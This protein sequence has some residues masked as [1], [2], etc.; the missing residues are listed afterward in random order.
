MKHK[1][2]K[3]SRR[4]FSRLLLKGMALGPTGLTMTKSTA[5]QTAAPR[6]FLHV[7][8]RGGWD[9]AFATDPVV[10][11]K[12]TAGGYDTTYANYSVTSIAGKA[13]L[14]VG[15]GLA[16]AADAF[17]NLPTAFVNGM[18]LDV[19]AHELAENYLYSGRASLTLSRTYPAIAALMGQATG[20]FPGHVVLGPSV[21]LGDSGE[22]APVL[23]AS[24]IDTLPVIL[25]GAGAS[26]TWNTASAAAVNAYV[27]QLDS[28]S[29]QTRDASFASSVTGWEEAAAHLD[30][31]Y[32]AA[33]GPML[34]LDNSTKSRYG[35]TTN[36]DL[37]AMLAGAYLT[38]KSGLCPYVTVSFG[39]FDTHDSQITRQLPTLQAFASAF[40]VLIN[41][42][43]STSDP[44]DSTLTLAD[45]TTIVIGSEFSRT[46]KF[47]ADSGTDHWP[48]AS[49][50][51]MGK[52]VRDNTVIGA[53]DDSAMAM[54]WTSSG[55]SSLESSNALLPE[56]IFAALLR[57]FGF[58]SAAATISGAPVDGLFT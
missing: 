25:T 15:A 43:R 8:L 16:A 56:H 29:R 35:S 47:N 40:N 9:T 57:N 11:S 32:A 1:R 53:T 38:L 58:D 19:T 34:S 17:A 12:T 21:P 46:P 7:F 24:S 33:Y 42:L 20:N 5:L 49:M 31:L 36:A 54:G 45:T 23:H 50:I 14:R 52:G 55:A 22:S 13:N 28:L 41:D 30:E 51:I 6:R 2:F 18:L 44:N 37:Q 4:D 3:L 48:V 27:E 26:S 39:N 10:G